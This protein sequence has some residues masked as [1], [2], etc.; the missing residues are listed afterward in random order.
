M[1]QEKTKS[2]TETFLC[3][4]SPFYFD[5]C[6]ICRAMKMAEERGRPL[7]QSELK[8]AFRQAENQG[9]VVGGKLLEED[10]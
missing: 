1:T 5:D 4:S 9:A 3:S 6:P 8:E 2:K 10:D 7:S